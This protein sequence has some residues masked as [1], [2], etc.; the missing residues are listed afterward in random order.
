MPN[1]N[2]KSVMPTN[3]M[4]GIGTYAIII[5]ILSIVLALVTY[6]IFLKP[7]NEDKY[8]GFLKKLYGFLSFKTMTLEIFLK[9][10]Y[11]FLTI[12]ITIFSLS[13][14]SQSFISFLLV[15]IIG[16]IS[17]RIIFEWSLIL[18]MLYKNTK[19]IRDSLKSKK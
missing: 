8:N 15:L 13:L 5:L 3:P 11:L 6:F 1:N 7:E 19:D 10:C 17:V 9:I 14:I 12:F 16:N 18:L 2:Y 4:N